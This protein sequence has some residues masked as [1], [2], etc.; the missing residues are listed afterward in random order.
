[1]KPQKLW[2]RNFILMMQGSFI[3]KLGDILYSIAI[4]WYVYEK[5]GSEA[6]LGIF[7]SIALFSSML[8]SPLA[9]AIADKVNRK[10]MLVGL[11]ALRGALMLL[12]GILCLQN[13]LPL[14]VLIVLTLFISVSGTFFNPCTTTVFIDIVPSSDLIRAHSLHSVISNFVQ[15]AGKAISGFLLIQCGIGWLIF[16]NGISFYSVP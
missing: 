8:L 16:F 4:G 2:N 1:M 5:T 9:G 3:S 14:S 6:M 11:D 12:I 13:K 7:T 15:L 10:S